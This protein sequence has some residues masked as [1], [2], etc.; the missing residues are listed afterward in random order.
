MM[1]VTERIRQSLLALHMARALETLDHTLSRLEKGEISAIEAIDDLLAEE[2]NLREGRRIRQHL[3][4]NLKQHLQEMPN[5]SRRA[6]A[7][8]ERRQWSRAV[9]DP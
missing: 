7:M 4:G 2:L 5:T 6:M 8:A 3:W 1:S 9:N